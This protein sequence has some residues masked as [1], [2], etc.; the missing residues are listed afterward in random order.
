MKGVDVSY[1]NDWVDWQSL[2]DAGIEFAICRTGFGK[3]GFDETFARNVAGAH[4]VGMK[5]GAYHYSYAMTPADAVIEADFC[6]RIIHETGCLLE[7]PVFF[8]MEDDDRYKESRGFDFSRCNITNICRAFLETIAPLDAGVYASYSWLTSLIDW[9][10]LGC[11]IWNAQWHSKDDFKGYAWQ[12]SDQII[13]NGKQF[14]GN[15]IYGG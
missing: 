10:S 6:K 5:C 15:I 1:F 2:K 13:I 4:A 14:D 7:L 12:Y 3:G 9:Q 11:P 8:D